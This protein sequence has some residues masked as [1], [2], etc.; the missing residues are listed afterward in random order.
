MEAGWRK[1]RQSGFYRR[2]RHRN[3][4]IVPMAIS[5]ADDFSLTLSKKMEEKVRALIGGI[6]GLL[7][8]FLGI[9]LEIT[10][11]LIKKWSN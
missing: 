10:A 9:D 7:L 11:Y 2:V 8:V 1:P 4:N 3:R 5:L 6:I